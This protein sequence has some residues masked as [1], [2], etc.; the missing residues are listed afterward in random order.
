MGERRW[1]LPEDRKPL[2]PKQRLELFMRQDGLC[3]CCS[4][5]LEVK[6]H[7]PVAVD[8]HLNPLWRGGSNVLTNRELWCKPCTKPKTAKEATE[9]AKANAVR[10]KHI[11]IDRRSTS[12]GRSFSQRYKRKMSGDI[13]DK[14]TGEI[15][16]KGNR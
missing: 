15:I 6:G 16:R 3:G 7:R 1:F 8:E 12:S 4:Q 14:H 2:T 5:R 11:G 13:V 9:R 10:D